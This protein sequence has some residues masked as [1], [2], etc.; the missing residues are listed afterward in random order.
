MDINLDPDLTVI[1]EQAKSA[2]PNPPHPA[3]IPLEVLRAGYVMQGQLQ[4]TRGLHCET[5]YDTAIESDACVVP[6]RVYRAKESQAAAPGLIFIHGGGFTIGNLDSHDSLCRQ[7]AIEASV[8]VIAIDYR[9]APEHK[10]PAAVED[11]L[12]AT[13]WILANAAALQLQ[14]NK[15]AIGGDSAGG[16]LS[17]VICN[18]LNKANEPMPTCQLLIYPA[19][20]TV[21]FT[22]PSRQALASGVTLDKRLIDFFNDM[23][24]GDTDIDLKDPRLCPALAQKLSGAP[25]AH[26]IT[27]EYDPLRDEGEEYSQLLSAAG[28]P[29]TYRCYEGLMHN[30]ILQTAVVALANQAVSDCANYLKQQLG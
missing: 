20:R 14:A 24:F 1:V 2:N 5:V 26:I 6:V 27:A 3:D 15:I 13:R 23:Y 7:L 29:A 21:D 16:N 12:A 11:C 30:F 25:P 22:T 18:E 4:A 28:V 10:F 9:L 19:T 17:A 8:T